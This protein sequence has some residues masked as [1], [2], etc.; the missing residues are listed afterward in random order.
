MRSPGFPSIWVVSRDQQADSLPFDALE[1]L[2]RSWT[3][4]HVHTGMM[5]V[6]EPY[7][8]SYAL[9]FR[10]VPLRVKDA[11]VSFLVV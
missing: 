5:L 3:P 4:Q 6:N 7:L 2:V 1:D 11:T 9:R 8:E 10:A